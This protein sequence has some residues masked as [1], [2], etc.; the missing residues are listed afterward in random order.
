MDQDVRA[1]VQ[2]VRT[3][4]PQHEHHYHSKAPP[5]AAGSRG[6]PKAAVAPG[7]VER[8]AVCE[9]E[10]LVE[11]TDVGSIAITHLSRD[12]ASLTRTNEVLEHIHAVQGL[13]GLAF[14]PMLSPMAVCNVHA[15]TSLLQS[16][17]QH[18]VEYM[19]RCTMWLPSYFIAVSRSKRATSMLRDVPPHALNHS[20][21]THTEVR[22]HLCPDAPRMPP[23]HTLVAL[24]V[25]GCVPIT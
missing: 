2:L 21:H 9:C 23:S 22:Q 8:R 1:V 11:A 5:A 24:W 3:P 7:G 15:M 25:C 12:S 4:L 10:C 6:G 18:S 17:E 19:A 16:A 14:L 13:T 20:S